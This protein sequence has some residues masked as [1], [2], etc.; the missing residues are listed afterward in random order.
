MVRPLERHRSSWKSPARPADGMI[1]SLTPDPGCV[2]GVGT[3]PVPPTRRLA[4]ASP[5]GRDG[6]RLG[7]SFAVK[8]Y[9]QDAVL[10]CDPVAE[11]Q[12]GASLRFSEIRDIPKARPAG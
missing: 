4:T 11:V 1:L 6:K 12:A 7:R 5:G 2:P 3:D 10:L 8:D 9:F